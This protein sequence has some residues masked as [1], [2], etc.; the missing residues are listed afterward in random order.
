MYRVIT[1]NG[2]EIKRFNTA[3]EAYL[4]WERFDGIYTDYED[5]DAEY[6]IYVEEIA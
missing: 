4:Y 1:E 5:N 6:Y 2:K 3:K